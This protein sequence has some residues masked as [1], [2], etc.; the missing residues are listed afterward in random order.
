MLATKKK[1]KNIEIYDIIQKQDLWYFRGAHP[2]AAWMCLETLRRSG[3]S[4]QVPQGPPAPILTLRDSC[5]EV[6]AA[7]RQ[8]KKKSEPNKT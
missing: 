5:R 7:Y 3:W 4:H 1:R 2:Q 8:K 6:T